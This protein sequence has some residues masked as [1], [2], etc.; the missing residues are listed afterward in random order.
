MNVPGGWR[1]WLPYARYQI[2][3]PVSVDTLRERLAQRIRGRNS[4]FW[5]PTFWRQLRRG[6]TVLEGRVLEDR[7]W[8]NARWLQNLSGAMRTVGEVSAAPGGGRIDAVARPDWRWLAISVPLIAGMGAFSLLVALDALPSRPTAS[9][10]ARI[11]FPAGVALG[12][13][14]TTRMMWQEV[15]AGQRELEL[16]A[17]SDNVADKVA[18]PPPET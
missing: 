17:G 9:W 8:F 15:A 13:L 12:H 7:F 1:W 2:D 10:P 5:T 18:D 14:L 6:E 4:S 3:A 11:L 16:L